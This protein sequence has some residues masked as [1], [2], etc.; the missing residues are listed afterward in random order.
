MSSERSSINWIEI[1]QAVGAISKN[2]GE[3][4]GSEMA[5]AA[6]ELIVGE[7][8]LRDAVE[9]YI[10]GQPGSELVRSVLWQIHPWCAMQRCYE[11]F[12]G[13]RSLEDRITAVELL[14]VVADSRALPW[15]PEFLNDSEPGIQIW[16][17]GV[18]DQLL[19]GGGVDEMV[20]VDL[21]EMARKHENPNVRERAEVIDG[22][23]KGR[24]A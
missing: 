11:I 24:K 21:L 18:L 22:Y 9:Y 16:G 4:G 20:C 19:W 7:Q 8:E 12:K 5:R 1:A 3:S 2:H 13:N 14:R 10:S 17:V 6:L 15:I 23:L